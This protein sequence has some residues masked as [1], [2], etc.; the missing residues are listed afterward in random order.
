MWTERIGK[1]LL[2]MTSVVWLGG[3]D[4]EAVLSDVV[5]KADHI[6]LVPPS[7]LYGPGAFVAKRGY[8]PWILKP[9]TVRLDD[10]CLKKYST[11]LYPSPPR[12]S[13]T[14]NYAIGSNFAGSF[15]LDLPTVKKVFGLDFGGKGV[16]HVIVGFSNPK[17]FKY[18]EQDLREIRKATTRGCIEIINE[19]V[20]RKNAYQ[21]RSVLQANVTLD[22]VLE[23]GA[24]AGGKL[25]A[26][27]K[28]AEIDLKVDD[29][30]DHL[31][32]EGVA[33]VYGV[34]LERIT[35]RIR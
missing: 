14:S 17:I 30:S 12:D 28:M 19:Y 9:E 2:L 3:C 18:S 29:L 25:E 4:E 35:T 5:A 6:R 27:R 16:K 7:T 32:S 15:T 11:D 13:G 10:L 21:V 33:L 22:F 8:D 20:D 26:I 1:A 23:T 24:S 34:D 31:H